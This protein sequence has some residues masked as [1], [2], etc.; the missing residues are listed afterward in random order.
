MWRKPQQWNNIIAL[1]CNTLLD[2]H[3]KCDP[4]SQQEKR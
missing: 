4:S 3:L 2:F 1:S